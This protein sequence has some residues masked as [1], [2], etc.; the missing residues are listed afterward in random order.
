MPNN[1]LVYEGNNPI[2]SQDSFGSSLSLLKND[3]ALEQ[4][5]I[6]ATKAIYD[7][8]NSLLDAVQQSSDKLNAIETGNALIEELQKAYIENRINPTGFDAAV[9]SFKDKILK[10]ISNPE[11]RALVQQGFDA[12]VNNTYMQIINNCRQANDEKVFVESKKA[13]DLSAMNL[14]LSVQNAFN[15]VGDMSPDALAA[16]VDAYVNMESA[17]NTT[18]SYNEPIFTPKQQDEL[19]KGWMTVAVES[20]CNE[21]IKSLPINKQIEFA[22]K[23]QGGESLIEFPL[24]NGEKIEISGK[25]IGF[26]NF[27][28]VSAK[29]NKTVN[30]NFTQIKN[31][32]NIQQI[33]NVAAGKELPDP[34]NKDYRKK[35]DTYYNSVIKPNL[36]FD[37]PE[38]AFSS[39]NTVGSM[40]HTLKAIPETLESDLRAYLYSDN[41]Q[42][43]SFASDIV[44]SIQVNDPDLIEFLPQKDISKAIMMNRLTSSGIPPEQAFNQ[45]NKSFQSI[46]ENIMDQRAKTFNK[47]LGDPKFQKKFEASTMR[48][49]WF[50]WKENKMPNNMVADEFYYQ[51]TDLARDFYAMGADEDSARESALAVLQTK[52]GNSN[53]NGDN[54]LTALPPEKFYSKEYMDGKAMRDLLLWHARKFVEKDVKDENIIVLA[55]QETYATAGDITSKPSYC[56]CVINEM[57]IP[58]PVLDE[59]NQFRRIGENVWGHEQWFEY[60]KEKERNKIK[61][62]NISSYFFGDEW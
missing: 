38:N 12:K 44:K 8:R 18:N 52:W 57:G 58:E 40:I 48:T 19:R 53:V 14:S 26:D 25:D 41:F 23:F 55:D 7:Q 13:I 32:E 29:I 34:K 61:E 27:K 54:L 4:S 37:S 59:E 3:R 43:F 35:V 20:I 28:S 5:K 50:F 51:F 49:G 60:T 30:D 16:M 33:E 31:Q 42:A 9:R 24:P 46:N 47:M 15:D 6:E 17:L 56:L 45:I 21:T 62:N 22:G 39:V 36:S 11:Q 10:T 2:L 1:N